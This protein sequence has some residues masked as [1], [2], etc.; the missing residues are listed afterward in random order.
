M[1]LLC[2][3]SVR[4]IGRAV[5]GCWPTIAEEW[6]GNSRCEML[7]SRLLLTTYVVNSLADVVANDGALTLREALQAANSNTAVNEASAG[8]ESA[9]DRIQFAVGGVIN[10]QL[11]E[12]VVSG[13]TDIEGSV[14]LDAG[15]KSRVMSITGGDVSLNGLTIRNGKDS[16]YYGGGIFFNST[17]SLTVTNSTSSGNTS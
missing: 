3:R 16:S 1:G 15:G 6:Q 2:T 14:T 8:S 12:L 9:T 10:L 17:G 11:G 7:E 4:A 5:R 13:N